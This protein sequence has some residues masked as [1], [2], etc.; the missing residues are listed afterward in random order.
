MPSVVYLYMTHHILLSMHPMYN[1]YHGCNYSYLMLTNFIDISY[2][3]VVLQK[4]IISPNW[5]ILA[6]STNKEIMNYI[7]IYIYIILADAYIFICTWMQVIIIYRHNWKYIYLYIVNCDVD[8]FFELLK[9]T[10]A[11]VT[12]RDD[13]R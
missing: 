12:L 10:F 6:S 1:W 7:Y 2:M 11:E 5:L 8:L 3:G 13:Q 4:N 9:L